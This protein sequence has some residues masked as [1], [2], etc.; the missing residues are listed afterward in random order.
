MSREDAA[1]VSHTVVDV[2]KEAIAVRYVPT[3]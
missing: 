2:S 3:I 1:T